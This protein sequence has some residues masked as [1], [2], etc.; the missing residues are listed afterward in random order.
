[1]STYSTPFKAGTIDS[2]SG[3]S[4]TVA[5]F[6]PDAGDVGR[7][8]IIRTGPARL[9]HREI[10]AVAGQVLTIAHPWDTNPFIDPSPDQRGSD[11]LPVAGDSIC[12][13]YNVADLI[14]GDPDMTLSN[15]RDLNLTG[16]LTTT[17]GAYLHFRN[18]N[19]TLNY[20]NLRV[21]TDSGV[22]F[23]YYSYFAGQDGV[24]KQICNIVETTG[25][26]SGLTG[27]R[28]TGT[29]FGLIDQYGGSFV[30]ASS[31]FFFIRAQEGISA[32]DS[33]F[34]MMFVDTYGNFGLRAGG[35]RSMVVATSQ[36]SLNNVGWANF[37][38]AVSRI[39]LEVVD[40]FQGAFVNTN[41]GPSGRAI[42]GRLSNITTRLFR[43]IAVASGDAGVFEFTAKKSELDA[44]PIILAIEGLASIPGHRF[45]YGNFIRPVYANADLS[46]VAGT[47]RTALVD[48]TGAVVDQQTV[49]TSQFTEFFARHTEI[50]TGA[51]NFNLPDGTLFA[52][53]SLRS[54]TYGKQ[55]TAS[56]ID[57]EDTFDATLVLLDDLA[58]TEPSKAVVDAYAEIGT[59]ERLY[60]RSV[61]WLQDN[62][63]SE[64][65]FLIQAS[66]SVLDAGALNIVVDPLAAAPFAVAGGTITVRAPSLVGGGKFTTLRTTGTV[67]LPLASSIVLDA[68]SVFQAT[69]TNI[70]DVDV[71]GTLV[72]NTGAPASVTYTDS[73]IA[74]VVNDGA[75]TVTIALAGSSSVGDASDP[76]INLL[77]ASLNFTDCAPTDQVRVRRVS[78]GLLLYTAAP[79]VFNF[80]VGANAGTEVYFERVTAGGLTILSTFTTATR[81]LTVGN[82]GTFALIDPATVP[83]LAQTQAYFDT[84]GGRTVWEYPTR[85]AEA[86]N[87]DGV[88]AQIWAAS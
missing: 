85:S 56:A 32:D 16:I 34:R 84:Y 28:S 25:S 82:N 71:T 27:R 81:V 20:A 83:S 4:L 60:D 51:G 30:C 19:V 41:L 78:D 2:F 54:V 55:F 5:G 87:L 31:A 59:L 13:S 9:Q 70:T 68:P 62:L 8:V 49:T 15:T 57:A 10:T 50:P 86:S 38:S 11:V 65:G 39:E 6:T 76:Q 66:G 74:T 3:T 46:A 21:G 73:A 42:F 1:M 43:V 67:T 79:G 64:A 44:I 58:I 36:G 52:P 35:N 24:P 33:Q 77:T 14:A 88:T 26:Q 80:S 23:G 29:D 45:R 17:G 63:T 47:I 72:Y 69:P 75:A 48:G 53:Y 7:L 61:S 12:L 37:L 18:F 40:C 22:I